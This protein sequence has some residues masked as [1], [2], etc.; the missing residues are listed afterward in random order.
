MLICEILQYKRRLEKSPQE[1]VS[2]LLRERGVGWLLPLI[3]QSEINQLVKEVAQKRCMESASTQTDFNNE[4][5]QYMRN[6]QE[7]V[8]LAEQGIQTEFDAKSAAI[9][10]ATMT[11]CVETIDRGTDASFWNSEQTES[12]NASIWASRSIRAVASQPATSLRRSW[13]I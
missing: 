1:I 5:G 7:F 4:Q 11:D 8:P 12:P 9:A 10:N 6:V 3:P 13:R 2:E